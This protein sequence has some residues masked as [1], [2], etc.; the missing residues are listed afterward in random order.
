MKKNTYLLVWLTVVV[1]YSFPCSGA[2]MV[3]ALSPDFTLKDGYGQQRSLAKMSNHQLIV[4]YFFSLDSKSS[5]EGLLTLGAL[6]KQYQQTDLVVWGI[7]QADK[8]AVSKFIMTNGTT[9]P[10]LPDDGKVS[11]LYSA[12]IILPVTCIIGPDMKIID[13]LQGGGRGTEKMLLRLA[14]RELQRN[15]PLFAQALSKEAQ[16]ENPSSI[17]AKSV[18]GYAA[19]KAE[20]YDEAEQVFQDLAT[21]DTKGEIIGKEG[22]AAVY[23]KKGET[24]KALE[25]IEEVSEKAPERGYVHLVKGDILYAQ[26][27]KEQAASEYELAVVNPDGYPYQKS[28][29]YNQLGRLETERGNYQQARQLYDRAVDIDP[30]FIEA[31]SNKGV[32]YQKEGNWEKALFDFQRAMKI[33]KDDAFSEVL[34]AKAQ[35]MI[36][37][38]RDIARRE[39]VDSLVKELAARYR[40]QRTAPVIDKDTWT[41]RPMVLSFIDFQEKGGLAQRDG[42]SL[43]LTGRLTDE[44]NNSGRLQVVE[45]TVLDALLEELNLG[46]SE[47]ADPAVTLKLGR[48]L[49]AKI[50]GSGSLMNLPNSTLLSLRLIDTETTRVAKVFTRKLTGGSLALVKE[51]DTLYREVLETVIKGYPLRGFIVEPSVDKVIVNLGEQQG[52]VLGTRFMVLEEGKSITYKGKVLKGIAKQIGEVEVVQVEPQFCTARII[53][54]ERSFRKDD[55]VK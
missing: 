17:D 30:Y 35:E 5:I 20:K 29:A 27:K 2:T 21:E 31:M 6:H 44:L 24:K 48:I 54:A 37:L 28:L 36:E 53:N 51:T 16:K 32:T 22:L 15:Q 4:L 9:F 40:E 38:Q 47:L 55:K 13:Y 50:I 45:R 33:N 42:L 7:T 34:A 49:A 14:Q 10:I 12:D 43:V 52:V 25:A 19:L 23:A 1:L 39:R 8:Q 41:S 46:S 26:N 3:G 11:G 18:Y